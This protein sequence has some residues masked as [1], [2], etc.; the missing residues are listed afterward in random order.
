MPEMTAAGPPR[1]HPDVASRLFDEEAFV[2]VPRTGSYEILNK[3][4]T[5][6]WELIDGERSVEEIVRI[7]CEEYEVDPEQ[8][9][10]D[11]REVLE[12]FRTHEMLAP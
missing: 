2:V 10:A 7:I 8:A 4:G 3:V 12:S 11:V 6:V 9:E 5:R 1:K